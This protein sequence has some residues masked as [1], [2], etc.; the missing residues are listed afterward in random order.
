MS[1]E[2]RKVGTTWATIRHGTIAYSKVTMLKEINANDH[3]GDG[4]DKSTYGSNF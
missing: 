1:E 2:M 4:I 3:M